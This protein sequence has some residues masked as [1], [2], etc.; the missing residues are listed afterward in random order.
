[1]KHPSGFDLNRL[2][3]LTTHLQGRFIDEGKIPGCQL[4]LM[5]HGHLAY[6]RSLGQMD[7]QRCRSMTD[8]AIFRIFS[9]TKPVTSVALM[10][11]YERGL[12]QLDDPV[13]RWVPSWQE[14]RVYVA[15]D[16]E[17]PFQTEPL[18]RPVSIRDLL[19]HTSGLTYGGQLVSVGV[20]HPVDYRYRSLRATSVDRHS[21]MMEFM[22][23]LSQIPL[24]YQPG[25]R[26]MY[27]LA[28]DACGALVEIIAGQ[29]F[30]EFLQEH[31]FDPLGM[32]DTGFQV[33]PNQRSRFVANYR[34]D[35]NRQ[36]EL[37]DDP[38]TSRYLDEPAFF[39]GG[40]GLVGTT[41]DYLR[42]CEMLRRGGELDGA[43]ILGPRTLE[44]MTRNHL[45]DGKDLSAWALGMFSESPNR[46]VGFGLGF[47]RVI[48]PVVAGVMGGGD[49]YWG[50]AAST[51]F[52]V[53]PQEQISLVFMTQLM[54]SSTYNFRG[55]LKNIIYSAIID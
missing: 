48:D 55:Q 21:G 6:Q 10:M 54:P 40:G 30:P 14:Q 26:W 25:E 1:M 53:D 7:L 2:E 36:L 46:G 34:R 39:S 33:R 44:M 50:G 29:S 18:G 8:D 43:R 11:L 9:M 41:A 45:K 32:V 15:G 27:S 19:R 35:A 17:G 12:F 16:G 23:K 22:D 42:F 31:V 3:R 47:A 28:T 5:R 24:A 38:E 20:E 51:L 52:L 49:Y 37:I 4:A 13:S